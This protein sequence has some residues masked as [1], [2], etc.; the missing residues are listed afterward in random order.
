MSAPNIINPTTIL[1]KTAHLN[2]TNTEA[3]I[4]AAV[5]T[6]HCIRVTAVFACNSTSN[7]ATPGWISLYHKAGG[8]EYPLALR[9]TVPANATINLLDGKIIY[10]EEGDSLRAQADGSGTVNINTA[11]EDIS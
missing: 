8:T 11:Y 7:G 10:L 6:G 3:D 4:I 5:A 9:M 2:V 1:G